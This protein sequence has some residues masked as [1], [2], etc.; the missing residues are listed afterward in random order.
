MGGQ[1]MG[2]IGGNGGRLSAKKGKGDSDW[3][4]QKGELIDT[5]MPG[6]E[7]KSG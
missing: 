3:A 2:K 5:K 7:F 1:E 6:G 4:I